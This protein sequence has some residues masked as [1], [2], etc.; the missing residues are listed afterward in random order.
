MHLYKHCEI[1]SSYLI[2]LSNLKLERIRKYLI[3]YVV[4]IH[5]IKLFQA[6]CNNILTDTY[7]NSC[8]KEN[9]RTYKFQNTRVV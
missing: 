9:M 8:T 2:G 5:N 1:C 6:V 7:K 3:Y 4:R